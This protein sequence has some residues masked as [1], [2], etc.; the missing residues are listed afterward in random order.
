[1]IMSN[2]TI[3]FG[4]TTGNTETA[5]EQIAGEF[6]GTLI[7]ISSAVP[8]NFDADL[9]ILGCSTWGV[10]ELQ[11]D[12]DSAIS[13]IDECDLTGKTIALFG[14]GDSCGFGDSFVGALGI[15]YDAV[16]NKGARVIGFCS[17][18]DYD[19]SESTAI[20]DDKF[21]GLPL[22]EENES[23]KTDDRIAQWVQQLKTEL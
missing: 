23:D 4:S 7:N 2:V 11:D 19:F 12:W 15:L 14:Y 21:V 8:S 1:M 6:E 17:T 16:T 20:R 3:I 22:D 5:A 18:D 10:G 9:I 13:L